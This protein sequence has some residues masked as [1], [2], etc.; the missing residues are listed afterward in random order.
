[1]EKK[2]TRAALISVLQKL[3]SAAK[4]TETASGT[5]VQLNAEEIHI[6]RIA[7]AAVCGKRD[8]VACAAG[9]TDKR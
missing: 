1:M 7:L 8:A 4:Q 9:D 6:L 2:P 3:N 5:I